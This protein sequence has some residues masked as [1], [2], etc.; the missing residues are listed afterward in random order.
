[1]AKSKYERK[2]FT[3]LIEFDGKTLAQMK[4]EINAL[5]DTY[6]PEAKLVVHYDWDS[7]DTYI[8]VIRQ[9]TEEEKSC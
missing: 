1:M 5:T 4:H 2:A 8:E 9:K 6:G 3:W 7:V